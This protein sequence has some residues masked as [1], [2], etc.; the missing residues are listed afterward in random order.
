MQTVTILKYP[1]TFENRAPVF[2]DGVL[3]MP[4]FYTEEEQVK[5]REFF[6]PSWSKLFEHQKVYVEYCSGNGQ[7]L[8]EMAKKHPNILWI[9]C[10]LKYERVKKIYKRV[11]TEKITNLIICFGQAEV[12]TKYYIP[13]NSLKAVFINFPDP[14]PK[15]KHAKHRL[16]QKP[17]L[18]DLKI[19]M[20]QG[21]SICLA[22]DDMPYL[23]QAIDELTLCHFFPSLDSPF[24]QILPKDYGYSFFEDLWTLKGKQN[25][26][27]LFLKHD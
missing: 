15:K 12:L 4:D 23:L 18:E 10:E 25:F 27:T 26:Q 2:L 9:G 20:A 17:F 19:A 1:Y 16:F 5:H 11:K 22:T 8:C 13:K 3:F 14:W 6:D 21:A 24:Y 7:W